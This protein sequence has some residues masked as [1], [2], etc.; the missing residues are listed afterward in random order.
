MYTA[1]NEHGQ[2]IYFKFRDLSLAVRNFYMQHVHSNVDTVVLLACDTE[3]QKG[4][5]WLY[6]RK[7]R[8]PSSCAYRCM[9]LR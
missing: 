7:I 4:K 2:D 5:N 8:I 9:Q 3:N 1:R 6:Q